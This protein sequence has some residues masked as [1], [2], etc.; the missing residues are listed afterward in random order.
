MGKKQDIA[1]RAADEARSFE[2]ARAIDVTN[3][4]AVRFWAR[5]FGVSRRELADVVR[6]VGPNATAVA[7]KIEAPN[8]AQAGP[9]AQPNP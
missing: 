5:R 6:Q 2:E 9:P 4:R 3:K 7:L 8:D 1:Q